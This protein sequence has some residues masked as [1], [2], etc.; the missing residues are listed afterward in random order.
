MLPQ[1][2]SPTDFIQALD[3]LPEPQRSIER[4]RMIRWM[5]E[6]P[7]SES[8]GV[9]NLGTSED[10]ASS[11]SSG[12]MATPTSAPS[13]PCPV[14]SNET[15][16]QVD[17]E[18]SLTQPD[19]GD[20]HRRLKVVEA[21]V[22]VPPAKRR[23]RRTKAQAEVDP[24]MPPVVRSTTGVNPAALKRHQL[25]A[26]ELDIR[27][28]LGTQVRNQLYAGMKYKVGD[29]MPCLGYGPKPEDP[30]LLWPDW[31]QDINAPPNRLLQMRAAM[32][33]LEHE[34]Q[35]PENV[36]A[37]YREK[38]MNSA[39][40]PELARISWPHL[41]QVWTAQRQEA[42]DGGAEKRK[43]ASAGRRSEKR[44]TRASQMRSAVGD[45]CVEHNLDEL[46]VQ[47]EL[48]HDDWVGE[49]WSCDEDGT[50]NSNW[51]DSLFATGKL[52][53]DERDEE[54]AFAVL[55]IKRPEW[56]DLEVWNWYQYIHAK[57]M[58][59]VAA[60]GKPGS[61]P[62]KRVDIGR[63]SSLMPKYEPYDFMLDENWVKEELPKS[64]DWQR[65][66]GLPAGVPERIVRIIKPSL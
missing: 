14:S 46:V 29:R 54:D 60:N 38:W 34:R 32:M 52:T 53:V 66:P 15:T 12:Y 42:L 37:E 3:T 18:A 58:K 55:E 39:V 5:S 41:K 65:R 6:G 33:V 2:F 19:I 9:P 20:L 44:R 43:K 4:A 45:F 50:K 64:P 51:R 57:H 11:L 17:S 27:R 62:G 7:R 48:V 21:A 31:K 47:P 40:L 1:S 36:P 35:F 13:A 56:M 16:A 61:R 59:K 23:K 28:Y 30:N 24:L 49:E 8:V 26:S 10:P 25:D 22:D 63:T